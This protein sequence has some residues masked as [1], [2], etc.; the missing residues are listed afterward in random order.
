MI[1]RLRG[2]LVELTGSRAV[3]DVNGVGY[4]VH[5]GGSLGQRLTVGEEVALSISTQVR[6]DAI[7]LYGFKS[8]SSREAFEVL[9]SVKGLGPKLAST[10]LDALGLKKLAMAI[11]QE[12]TTALTSVSGIGRRTAERML[13]EL[14]GK[15][16]VDFAPASPT[17]SPAEPDE[18]DVFRL[19]L[20]RL[21]YRKS[22]ID[23]AISGLERAGANEGTLQ[24]RLSASLRIL[25]GRKR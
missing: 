17:I 7:S 23:L 10:V 24:E 11:H 18:G 4:L 13:V 6:E 20:A 21:G 16:N 25:S 22:E 12:D 8:P 14:R 3:I 2:E 1:A 9:L 5:V 19:A 15:L